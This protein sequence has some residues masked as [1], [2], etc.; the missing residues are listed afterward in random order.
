MTPKEHS[1][2]VTKEFARL[3]L[4]KYAKGQ[5]EHKGFLWE[6]PNLL[7]MAIEEVVDLA[8]YLISLKQQ[9]VD[10]PVDIKSK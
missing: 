1:R 8:F 7:D 10:K 4:I 5:K 6:K 2:Q 3:M 9:S